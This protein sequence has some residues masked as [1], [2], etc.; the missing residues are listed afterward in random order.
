MKNIET[1]G[2]FYA[3]I[4]HIQSAALFARHVHV[5]EANNISEVNDKCL[6]EQKAYV[7]GA[8]FASIAFLE[9][10]INEFFDDAL[11]GPEEH[12]KALSNEE[13]AIL[14]EIWKKD[15]FQM[16]RLPMINKFQ[17]ALMLMKR[18]CKSRN[19]KEG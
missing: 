7:T 9:A 19:P 15:L 18:G 1:S 3:S 13:K 2:R 14:G 5:I 10:T 8:I 6:A 11:D 16:A 12:L 4:Q 17:I